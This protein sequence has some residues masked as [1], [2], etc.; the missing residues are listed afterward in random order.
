MSDPNKVFPLWMST[1]HPAPYIPDEEIRSL[2]KLSSKLS[3]LK[4]CI[5]NTSV[6]EATLPSRPHLGSVAS[7][8]SA[9]TLNLFKIFARDRRC[10]SNSEI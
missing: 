10:A 2:I 3:L 5:F 4:R 9:E 6:R 7:V 1:P 8:P